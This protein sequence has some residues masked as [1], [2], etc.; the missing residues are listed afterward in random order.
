LFVLN[1][2]IRRAA[3]LNARG[4]AIITDDYIVSWSE[5]LNRAQCI[6]GAL[7]DAGVQRGDRIAIL[8]LNDPV[9]FQFLFG[10]I[11]AGAVV[12]PLNTR[13]SDAELVFCLNDLDGVWIC[14]DANL[15]PT[16]ARLSGQVEGVSGYFFVGEGEAPSMFTPFEDLLKGN[17][18][19]VGDDPVSED[20]AMI[21]YTG[22][23]TG[24]AKG[25]LLSHAN[26]K[27]AAQ[28]TISGLCS[29]RSFGRDSIYVHAAPM[30][31]MADGIMSFACAM[32]TCANTFIPRFEVPQFVEHCIRHKISWM[33]LVPTMVKMICEFLVD[34]RLDIPGLRGILYGA[35]P[36]P[37]PVLK[38]A[39]STL[40]GVQLFQ[41]YGSTEA[42]IISM[43]GPEFHTGEAGH[44]ALLCSAGTPF[45]GVLVGI[46]GENE[47]AMPVGE[48]GQV[49][50][51]SNAVMKGYWNRP[52]LTRNALA[53]NWLRTGDLGYVNEM[54]Y[55]FLVDRLKDMIITGGENVYPNEVETVLHGCA[56]VDECAVVGLADEKWGETIHAFVRFRPGTVSDER[57]LI[58]HCRKHLAGYKIPRTWHLVTDPLPRTAMGKLDKVHLRGERRI[59]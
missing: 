19:S 3:A 41:G 33:T 34:N 51:R 20:V 21:Y 27:Y 2:I 16:L 4:P 39:M 5:L 30:F 24:S 28:Q 37:K 31:H 46:F 52:D 44:E 38:L 58:K 45:P 26:I 15:R 11:W 17:P 54:G 47:Q 50:V 22:G 6:A 43:L 8:S 48:I 57:E 35:A 56:D 36:M 53:D 49:Y 10:A 7:R 23:T 12:V 32:V 25:V 40:P 9:Y 42:L 59:P 29:S 14:S 55:I 13:F 18:G 1:D